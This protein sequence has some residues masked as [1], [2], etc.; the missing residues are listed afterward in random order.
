MGGYSPTRNSLVKKKV[1]FYPEMGQVSKNDKFLFNFLMKDYGDPFNGQ[2]IDPDQMD[3][4]SP[5]FGFDN[6]L[7]FDETA[8]MGGKSQ[9]WKFLM[10]YASNIPRFERVKNYIQCINEQKFVRES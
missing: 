7:I 3:F 10:D 5:D 4:N 6:F 8:P 2:K 1:T 9:N